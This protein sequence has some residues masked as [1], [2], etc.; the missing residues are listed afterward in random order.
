[1]AKGLEK[2]RKGETPKYLT[3]S[4]NCNSNKFDEESIAKDL[5]RRTS[6]MHRLNN[7]E[8]RTAL[9][10]HEANKVPSTN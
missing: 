3:K 6:F 8:D 9:I 10:P 7:L 1:M 4:L 2:R 5:D